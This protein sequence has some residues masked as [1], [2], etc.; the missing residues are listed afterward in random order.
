M[1]WIIPISVGLLAGI[2]LVSLGSIAPDLVPR[3]ISYFVVGY[4]CFYFSSKVN[5]EK[6][7][8]VSK[9]MYILTL[10]ILFLL[11]I[12]G[13]STRSTVRWIN[14][15]LGFKI[16]PSQFVPMV[17]SLF[18]VSRKN[19]FQVD[20]WNELI[21]LSVCILLPVFLIF[22]QP[23]FGTSVVISISLFSILLI[24]SIKPSQVLSLLGIFIFVLVFTWFF[25][26]KPYQKARITGF[27]SSE[28]QIN[29]D[30]SYNARQALIAVG[31]GQLYGRGLGAG[32]QSHLRFLP[33]RQTD[34]IF[35]SIAEEWGFVGSLLI[36][37]LYL[38]LLSCLLFSVYKAND[39]RIKSLL[40][41]VFVN[42]FL[43]ISI[44]IGMNVGLL[45]I[46]G[47]TLP[48]LSYGGS[49]ILSFMIFLGLA[50]NVISL[51][52]P[53]ISLKIK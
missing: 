1:K 8:H 12:L 27:I 39:L 44:N 46:T 22:L 5:F 3:Q 51:H 50:F 11:L 33:E 15:P 23:D 45:P 49:S 47:L 53:R 19:F 9:I 25:A 52:K 21:K 40:I 38:A 30:T 29:Q 7:L 14:L 10:L 13:I 4:L 17:V 34:F 41:V 48:F 32:V 18:V 24:S 42:L 37:M 2:S 16:Q 26:L 28:G 31:S 20:H 6:L 35:A 36:I 43:Q